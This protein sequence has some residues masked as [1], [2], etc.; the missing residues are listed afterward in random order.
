MSSESRNQAPFANSGRNLS[1]SDAA[2][3]INSGGLIAFPTETVY[4]LGADA[5]NRTAV[6]EIFKL[7]GRPVTNPLIV[8]TNSL[9]RLSEIVLTDDGSER[10]ALN[11]RV[12]SLATLW[13]GPLTIVLQKSSQI[14]SNVTGSATLV[15]VRIP[16]H[17]LALEFLSLCNNPVAAPSANRSNRVSPTNAQHVHDEFGED[18]PVLD[19][20]DCDLGIESTVVEPRD[21]GIIIHRP[22]FITPE[23]IE[24]LAGPLI[25]KESNAPGTHTV[26]P[27]QLAQHYAPI[28]PCYLLS[29][30][31]SG[32]KSVAVFG[33]GSDIERSENAFP[34][35]WRITKFDSL[36]E[37]AARLYSSL[38][39]VDRVGGVDAI[40]M[41]P[42]SPTGL[43][44]AICD[45]LSRA[46]HR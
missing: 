12:K 35:A 37:F 4:G 19:G 39:D 41:I 28:T 44:L 22:G 24:S 20:G 38:R 31:P 45:R 26:S 16:A 17:P 32:L 5:T 9:D 34:H 2:K 13:P 21:S 15:G 7:K 6:A 30:L 11:S 33:L 27:G 8:H 46:T 29:D 43:G 42:P 3:L 1:P 25:S 40:A 23:Q 36:I 18:F 14:A 10:Q